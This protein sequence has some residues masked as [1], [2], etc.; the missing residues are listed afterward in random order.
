MNYFHQDSKSP[1][2]PTIL[3]I[4]IRRILGDFREK[5]VFRFERSKYFVHFEK[6]TF[7]VTGPL[8]NGITN[9]EMFHCF[10]I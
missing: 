4:I 6:N 1:P 3:I 5:T 9:I 7:T 10:K 2:P 8:G